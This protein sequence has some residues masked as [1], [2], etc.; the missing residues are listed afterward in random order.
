MT[1][2]VD[3]HGFPED[4]P[5]NPSTLTQPEIQALSS[6]LGMDLAG[7]F[8][9]RTDKG[10]WQSTRTIAKIVEPCT[11]ASAKKTK[12]RAKRREPLPQ[13][14]DDPFTG[15]GGLML[16]INPGVSSRVDVKKQSPAFQTETEDP[17]VK[18][19]FFIQTYRLPDM[20]KL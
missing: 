3:I 16:P 19:R 11:V 17:S 20:C 12:G 9:P 15:Q 6:V 8:F 10:C 5:R 14:S 4:V 2:N 1:I 18:Y 13:C 7:D